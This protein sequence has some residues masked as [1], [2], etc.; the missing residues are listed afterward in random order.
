[1]ARSSLAASSVFASLLALTL[2]VQAAPADAAEGRITQWLL[3]GP[4]EDKPA[5]FLDKNAL[6]E[7]AAVAPSP[8]AA[9]GD[10]KW[11]AHTTPAGFIN[12]NDPEVPVG[13]RK[14]AAFAAFVY[15]FSPKVQPARL[16]L[17]FS[18]GLVA[19]LNGRTVFRQPDGGGNA[20]DAQGS[21]VL[22]G[23]GWN[24]LLIECAWFARFRATW[25]FG[26]RLTAPGGAELEG[27][28]L[29]AE[30]P[31]PGG[32]IEEPKF[33]AF[34]QAFNI[35]H[36]GIHRVRLVN[37]SPLD[38]PDAVMVVTGKAGRKL[39]ENKLGTLKALGEVEV[40]IDTD[41]V[42]FKADWPGAVVEL[43]Y[44]GGKVSA[45]LATLKATAGQAAEYRTA[46]INRMKPWAQGRM[47]I[48]LLVPGSQRQTIELVQRG[49]FEYHVVD[50]AV[51]NKDELDKQLKQELANNQFD[52]IIAAAQSWK[53]MPGV[54]EL[55]AAVEKGAG[56][57]VVAPADLPE[58]MDKLLGLE[59]S[60]AAA[61]QP[62][63]PA[64]FER[65]LLPGYMAAPAPPKAES[66]GADAA[67]RDH[68]IISGEHLPALP[69]VAPAPLKPAAS[70]AI[71]AQAGGA[72]VVI[73]ADA[74]K[75]R[76]VVLNFGRGSSLIW[77]V[78][79][80]LFMENYRLPVWERQWSLVLK[81]VI[82]AGHKEGSVKVFCETA[83]KW[84]R[85]GLK[86]AGVGV[87]VFGAGAAKVA[88]EPAVR[89]RGYD[90]R[91]LGGVSFSKV[92][93]GLAGGGLLPTDLPAGESEIDVV[94]RDEQGRVLGWSNTTLAV[95]PRGSIG[96]IA[97]EPADKDFFKP[98]EEITF[99]VTYKAEVD[100]LELVGRLMDNHG[101]CVA[102]KKVPAPRSEAAT[103]PA[104]VG[105]AALNTARFTFKADGLLT[106]VGRLQVELGDK[107]G[108]DARGEAIFFVRHEFV[109]DKYEPV[110]WLTRSGANWYYDLDYFRLLH[111]V[112]WI[113]NGWSGG[114]G[115]EIGKAQMVY[116][117]LEG[118]GMES[119]HFFSMNHN[120]AKATFE[121]RRDKFAA[122][123]D[124]RWLYRTPID[125]ATGVPVEKPDYSK[126]SFGNDPY[127]TYFPLDDPEYQEFTRKKIAQQVRQVRRY[128]PL[129]YDLMDE[130]AYTT[131]ARA[132]D[133]DFSPVS[134]AA[135]RKWLQTQYKDVAAL[136]AEWGTQFAAW[137]EV[138]PMHILQVRDHVKAKKPPSYAPW[139][140]HRK[141][142]DYAYNNYLTLCT[143]AARTEDPD[144][145]V[146]IGGGQRP[147]PY[148]GWDYWLV[149]NHFSWIE[150]YFDDT[151][152]AIRSFNTP[153]RKLK[154]CPGADVWWSVKLG[155]VGFYR[156]VD[157]GHIAGDFSLLPRGQDTARQLEEVRG[158]GFS[159]LLYKAAPKDEPIG[160]H[161]SQ[162]AIQ[163]SYAQGGPGSADMFGNGGPLQA[164]L[165]YYNLIEE[166]G[167]QWK[168]VAYA[169]VEAGH[170]QQAGYKLMI[171]PE[172]TALSDK[173]AA[174]LKEWVEKGGVL[175]CDRWVGQWT[176]HG[177][178][179]EKSVLEESFGIDPA[180]AADKQVGKG[181][182]IYTNSDWPVQYLTARQGKDVKLY[183]DKMGD[184]IAKAGIKAPRARVLM[185]DGQPARRTE[186]RYFELGKVRYHVISAEVPGK[187][188]FASTPSDHA[189]DMRDGKYGAN[190]TI[191]IEVTQAFPALVALSPY[192]I[193]GV[194]AQVEK[195]AIKPGDEVRITGQVQAGQLDPDAIHALHFRVYGPDG[196]ERWHYA[197][198]VFGPA[199]KGT[200]TFKTALNEAQGKWTVK[201][202]DLASGQVGE[203]SFEVKP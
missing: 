11:V 48:L 30:N 146:G 91:K 176:D 29:S 93:A 160:I 105:A 130:G 188:T 117:G 161:Y 189:Y 16:T 46:C 173:E 44:T 99:V 100:N 172:S 148:G 74:G 137:D 36:F 104:P 13:T 150:N 112:M 35:E 62:G 163:L 32:K 27:F 171:L 159:K 134:I 68:P 121:L 58:A 52:C 127:N 5:E 92:A 140:D 167:Y 19:Q 180:Q 168:F 192:K 125:K 50:T 175:F 191:Q 84:A 76:T 60:A 153:D 14:P 80:E 17:T 193:N 113:P 12:V 77:S 10:K 123:K 97:V 158:R 7:P 98:G 122:T 103:R 47:K 64:K 132:L 42:T 145:Y 71:V 33:S 174:Q 197:D 190:G 57:V 183:W 45:P 129:T 15:V 73:A 143:E 177:R 178:K 82:W 201:V 59:A 78:P 2:L 116:A 56:L 107:A 102:E 198:T 110:L 53:K 108:A 170:L 69:P 40:D 26:A 65:A 196:V 63:K 38:L 90:A 94:L 6:G 131:Y 138:V 184:A 203:A 151:T 186:I 8:G 54:A 49:D 147:N 187:Y 144:A 135:F 157:Y 133:F 136:N 70:A 66:P 126:L 41:E 81:A 114:F 85:P 124:I 61:T 194:A 119:L 142:N 88:A 195:P 156:W 24:R 75:G 55:S 165:G 182:V 87:D 101:R 1:M 79:R 166:L 109:W 18:D 185:A 4:F 139:V 169:Q 20:V 83:D 115:P 67:Q 34:V 86:P 199:G 155:N 154:A 39:Q 149:S 202:A 28:K 31:F 23:A 22:L 152:E 164:K 51:E 120:W 96:K 95:E 106:T 37:I 200:H 141:Y 3:A 118:M 179:R 89:S 21:D 181:W 128:N 43:T 9:A 25:S 111:E 72:P 162:A